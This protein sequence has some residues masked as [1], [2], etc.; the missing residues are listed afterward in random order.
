M[1]TS[2]FPIPNAATLPLVS[3]RDVN[4]EFEGFVTVESKILIMDFF[5]ELDVFFPLDWYAL[6]VFVLRLSMFIW[7]TN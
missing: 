4:K 2:S 5:A 3:E 6:I 1:D 7:K